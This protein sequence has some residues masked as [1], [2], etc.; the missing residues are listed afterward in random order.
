MVVVD[1][2]I[3][4]RESLLVD[5]LLVVLKE[6][7]TSSTSSNIAVGPPQRLA[8]GDVM[9]LD[10]ELEIMV[11]RKQQDDLMSSLFDGRLRDQYDRL[12]A[13]QQDNPKRW[14]VLVIEGSYVAATCRPAR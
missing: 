2:T 5:T 11:E 9:L 1:V 12:H 4:D 7:P 13:W 8:L 10:D 6:P 3:D 14:V